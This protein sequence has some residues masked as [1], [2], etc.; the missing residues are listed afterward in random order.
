TQAH[1]V[2]GGCERADLEQRPGTPQLLVERAALLL[3]RDHVGRRE[4]L[5]LLLV[6]VGQAQ[7]LHGILLLLV[8]RGRPESTVGA[9]TVP[10]GSL[11]LLQIARARGE[12]ASR[13]RPTW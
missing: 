11:P 6:V 8:E 10:A 13:L 7:I 2:L 4:G 5:E 3:D 1:G 9:S 12:A